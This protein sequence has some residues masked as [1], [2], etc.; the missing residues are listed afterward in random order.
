MKKPARA[1]APVCILDSGSGAARGCGRRNLIVALLLCGPLV[2]IRS[3]WC[4]RLHF[5]RT[6]AVLEE[7]RIVGIVASPELAVGDRPIDRTTL[8]D[9]RAGGSRLHGSAA[10]V[11]RNRGMSSIE[12]ADR[13]LAR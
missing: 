1:I 11:E 2:V 5:H 9:R 10:G 8:Q 6:A 7:N 3:Q 12:H 13:K 4:Q